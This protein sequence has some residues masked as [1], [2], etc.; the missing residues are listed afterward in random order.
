[1]DA[2]FKERIVKPVSTQFTTGPKGMI[3]AD[4]ETGEEFRIYAD[5]LFKMLKNSKFRV[6]AKVINGDKS[7]RALRVKE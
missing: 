5:D 1:M 3:F 6:T 2:E 7:Y 4:V